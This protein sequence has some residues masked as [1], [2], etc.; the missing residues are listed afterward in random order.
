MNELKTFV[1]KI[2]NEKLNLEYRVDSMEEEKEERNKYYINLFQESSIIK[3]EERDL[4]SNWIFPHYN[5]KFELLY[6]G[7]RDGFINEAFHSKCDDKG[8][9]VFVVKLENN[10]RLGGF[11]SQYGI[12]EKL[13][14]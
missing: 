7:T 10:R 3:K 8:P 9:T 1:N 12:I 4:I 6:R 14:E 11:A 5:L 2:N 13:L